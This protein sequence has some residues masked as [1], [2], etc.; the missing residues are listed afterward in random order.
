MQA[1]AAVRSD[2]EESSGGEKT[3]CTYKRSFSVPLPKL[4]LPLVSMRSLEFEPL[5]VIWT[6][7][8]RHYDPRVLAG[9]IIPAYALTSGLRIIAAG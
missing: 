9:R 7:S 2:C 6:K 3:P 8:V 1:A 4:A 5:V